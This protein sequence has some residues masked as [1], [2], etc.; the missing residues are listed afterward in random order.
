MSK[1]RNK[2]SRYGQLS[3]AFL[4][5]LRRYLRGF[6]KETELVQLALT[7]MIL[8]APSKYRAHDKYEGCATFSASDLTKKFGRD[9]FNLINGRLKI[10]NVIEDD[11][12]RQ[13]WSKRLGYTKAYMLQEQV[14]SLTD[15][16]LKGNNRRLTRLLNE[17]GDISPMPST[18]VASRRTDGQPRVGFRARVETA[19]PVNQ[20]ILKKLIIAIQA[21]LYSIEKGYYQEGLF[22]SEP[23]PDYLRSILHEARL[24]LGLSRN[25]LHPGVLIHRYKQAHSGRLYAQGIN[26]Q[27]T[28]RVIRQACMA[29]HY[30]YDIE[31]CHYSILEQMA[32]RHDYQCVSVHHYLGNK[33]SVRQGLADALNLTVDQAKQCLIALIYGA[34]FS[35][36]DE[37]AIPTI[38]G[39]IEKARQLYR[40]TFFRALKTDISGAQSAIL[41]GWPVSRQTIK[42]ER[43]LTI[44]IRKASPSQQLAHLMQGVESMALD[45][46]H[47]I[48]SDEIVLLQHDGFTATNKLDTGRLEAAI[49][50]KTGY[51]MEVS[52]TGRIAANLDAALTQHPANNH[53]KN[54]VEPMLARVSTKPLSV[55][56]CVL[57]VS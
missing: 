42:N 27:N 11:L 15:K 14:S 40:H 20:E 24:I 25:R 8:Q 36:R 30:D 10:F 55:N 4:K 17:Y 2:A 12:G 46:M 6:K 23:N 9:K 43:N 33:K 13:E 5:Y 53:L 52:T 19:V 39:G 29:G 51:R 21:K 7:E 56:T 1:T 44:D 48:Y 18:A 38:V 49:L 26:L 34:R 32:Q 3:E 54:I 35:V 50:E 45:A 41:N 22:H 57:Y 37:D 47:Q 31:N 28:Y 16:F